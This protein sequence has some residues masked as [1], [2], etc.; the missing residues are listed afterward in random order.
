[1][2]LRDWAKFIILIAVASAVSGFAGYAIGVKVDAVNKQMLIRSEQKCKRLEQSITN[3]Q[4]ELAK[5]SQPVSILRIEDKPEQLFAT[6]DLTVWALPREG[7]MP[8][9]KIPRG[10]V[11]SVL[12]AANPRG[13]GDEN[14]MWFY[15]Q[16]PW[17]G[18]SPVNT[19]GWVPFQEAQPYT[20]DLLS[21]VRCPVTIEPTTSVYEVD[22]FADISST[23]GFKVTSPL[24][25]II[26][27]VKDGYAMV[28]VG[29][30]LSV[31]VKT[32]DLILP[33]PR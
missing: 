15:V 22:N 25:G 4:Q 19:R 18:D 23:S 24:T 32:E 20:S 30:G 7:F 27:E 8:L 28:T 26:R 33:A 12:E 10:C 11:F 17:A 6:S 14:P 29:G 2:R 9:N 13:P 1:M 3:L 16:V 5:V 31:W 21:R